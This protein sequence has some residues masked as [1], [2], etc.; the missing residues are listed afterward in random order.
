MVL[1]PPEE[2]MEQCKISYFQAS[3]AGGQKR[4]RKLSAVRL[5]H[6]AT[7][8]AATA[9]ELRESARNVKRALQK[10]RLETALQVS[11][12]LTAGVEFD[13][14]VSRFRVNVS[15]GHA[16]FPIC[17]LIACHLF[18]LHEGGLG[19]VAKELDTSSAALVRFFKKDKALWARVQHIRQH[20]GHYPLK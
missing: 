16:D 9:S 15:D 3:G 1:L 19:A 14:P 13:I 7:N 17:A 11:P 5:T 10:L 12:E 18:C 4:N 6:T 8:I 2:F 20:Y